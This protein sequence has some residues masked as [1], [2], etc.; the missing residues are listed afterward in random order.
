MNRRQF[1]QASGWTSL[2]SRVMFA[3]PAHLDGMPDMLLAFLSRKLNALAEKWDTERAKIRS[4]GDVQARNR[5]VREKLREMVHGF[6]E[7]NPLGSVVVAKHERAD[8]RV[9]NVMFQSRPDFWVT[10]N[11]YVPLNRSGPFPGVISPCGH[12]PLSRMEPE[13]QSVYI[14]MVKAGFVVLAYDPI[15]QGERRQYWNPQTNQT[16]VASASTYEH[17]MP[18]QVLLLMGED[19]AHYRIWDGMRAIDYLESRPEVDKTRISCAG[20]SGGGTLTLFISALDERVK[21]AVVNEGGT[22]HRWPSE[23]RPESRVG[24]SDVEQNLFPAAVYGADMCDLHVAIAPRPLMVM[25]EEFNPRF[26]R[27]VQHIRTRYQQLQAPEKFAAEQATD[28][29]AWTPKLRIAATDWL[30]RWMYGR[31]GPKSEPDFATESAQTLFCTPNGSLR[32]SQQGESIFSIIHKKQTTL[33]SQGAGATASQIRELLHYRK[34]DGPQD[35]QVKVTTHRKGY[36]IEKLE[37]LSE[38]EIAIPTWVFVP[39]TKRAT[40]PAL[41]FVNESGKQADGMEFGLYERLARSGKLV[42]SVDVRGIGE[43]RPAHESSSSRMNEFSHLFD[44]E[45]AMAY[46]AWFMDESLF[47]MRVLDV[48]RSVDYLLSRPDVAKDDWKLTGKGA[49]ALWA[50]YAAALDTRIQDC[51]C[52]R[53]LVSYTSLAQTDR[54]LH[55]ASIFVR[56]VLKH[57]DLPQVAATVANRRLRLI[58]PVDAMRQRMDPEAAGSLYKDTFAA[59][60]AAGARGR[61]AIT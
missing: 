23:I 48:V 29:H 2:T 47:G 55:N 26:D 27:A 41:L 19:L 38:P 21:C 1:L 60:E 57:F 59:Y 37:F 34:V 17:S 54:Y 9:E 45:T 42:M 32:Y 8:Y 36:S 30:S 40:Y 50:L 16:E 18:G 5:F 35:P 53:G 44:V 51:T 14:N 12:Y 11:V 46:M 58:S 33:P 7:R 20:H 25:I 13:Y 31:P 24:P 4:A 43:T 52:E 10:G 49:G 56:D 15:G 3:T 28:P 39:D 22:A 61:F 6:P